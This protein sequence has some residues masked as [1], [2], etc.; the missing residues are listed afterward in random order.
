MITGRVI[1]LLTGYLFGSFLTAEVVAR[2]AA[3]KSAFEIGSHNPG[4]ANIASQLGKKAGAVVLAGDIVKTALA[5]LVAWILYGNT[6]GQEAVMWAGA[7]VLLGHNFPFWH[8]FRGGKGVTVTCT[9]IILLM[10]VWGTVSCI[11]GGLVVLFTK[12]LPLGAVAI[13]LAALIMSFVFYNLPY[14]I[15][16]LFAL[17]MMLVRNFRDLRR[18][19]G[20]QGYCN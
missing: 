7:G 16:M 4:M 14:R 15:F 11:I 6:L 8:R 13:P 17:I 20:L 10:P 3:G 5:A 18:L 1:S 9:V 19:A 12:K 2:V